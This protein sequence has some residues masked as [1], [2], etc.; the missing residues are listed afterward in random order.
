MR[1]PIPV[2]APRSGHGRSYL[3]WWD[4][5]K[6]LLAAFRL[7]PDALNE[8]PPLEFNASSFD[9]SVSFGDSPSYVAYEPRVVTPEQREAWINVNTA[10]H[11]HV[12]PSLNI[13]GAHYL[14]DSRM[15]DTF[16]NEHQQADGRGLI[17]WALTFISAADPK[18]QKDLR[19][20]SEISR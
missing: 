2:W 5:V 3:K 7:T 14:Q 17:N 13:D 4:A 18:L 6:K 15:L 10:I 12:V 19:Q 9:S 11:W 20:N 16:W 1:F 8:H